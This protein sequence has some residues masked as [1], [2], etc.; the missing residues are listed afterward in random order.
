MKIVVTANAEGMEA[1][2]SPVFGRSAY[3]VFV[4]TE[5]MESEVLENPA[6]GAASGAGVQA[7]QLMVQQGA[8]AV[9]S[10]NVGPNAFEV[11]RSAGVHVYVFEGGTVR[12]AVEAFKAG[13]LSRTREATG[14]AHAGMGPGRG[15]GM[16]PGRGR[17]RSTRPAVGPSPSSDVTPPDAAAAGARDQ[18][19]TEL[20]EMAAGLRRQLAEIMGRLDKLEEGE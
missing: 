12:Q 4:D 15:M 17:H 1:E 14:P 9:V 2:A 13:E 7:A 10:G 6:V 16:G 5:S 18:E 8:E 3:Y 11:L 19:I 20:K